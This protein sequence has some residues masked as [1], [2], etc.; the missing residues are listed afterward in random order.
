MCNFLKPRMKT[1]F[2]IFLT[3]LLFSNCSNQNKVLTCNDFK[4]GTFENINQNENK[5]FVIK[6]ENEKQV[7]SAYDLKTNKIIVKDKTINISWKKRSN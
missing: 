2:L 1:T 7:E 4:S 6:R 5:K 3:T